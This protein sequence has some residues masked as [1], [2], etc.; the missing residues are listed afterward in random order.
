M[1]IRIDDQ[2]A[3]YRQIYRTLRAAILEGRLA[4]GRR[5]PSSRALARENRVS[6]NVVL[7][8]YDQLVAEGYAE[9]RVGS[10][11]YVAPT[12]P[13]ALLHVPASETHRGPGTWPTIR[14]SPHAKR[15]VEQAFA[16]A[17]RDDDATRPRFDFRYGL[18]VPDEASLEVWRRMMARHTQTPALNYANA[19]GHEPLREAIADYVGRSRGIVCRPDQVLVVNGS[20][21]ALDLSARVLL[22][23]GDRV[24]VEEP[25]YTGAREI[26]LAAGAT[27]V[28]VPVDEDGLDVAKAPPEAASARVAYVTPSHQFPT[29]AVMPLGH[30]LKL[31]EWA[32]QQDAVILEDDYDSEYRYEGRP[33]E[34]IQA[35]DPE[36]RTVYIGTFSKVLFPSLRLGFVILPRTL[37][38]PFAAAKWLCD[39]HT[40]TVLQ[41]ALA[42]LLAEGHFE[43]HL[44]R[45]RTRHAARRAALIEGL[46]AHAGDRVEV[47][48]TNAGIHLLVWLRGVRADSTE[49]VIR[50]A[51]ARDVG[52]YPIAPFYMSPPS[53]AGLLFGY[54]AMEADEIREGIR[55][56][57]EVLS[58][59][60]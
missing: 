53:R 48:G 58:A 20:Q 43:R 32:R 27:L 56:F 1:L 24:L 40:P 10:G 47:M 8:A 3:I 38:K 59:F 5:L 54:A 17:W 39:R 6:R 16:D 22:E 49:A 9:S 57:G 11:T 41:A 31:L 52:L 14:I 51:R 15:A 23:E 37:V 42:D 60:P 55:R 26:L 18:A 35:L 44:R 4:P 7:L 29:G 25:H 19:V 36:G 50:A 12:L 45:M 33:I 13:E 30:R 34:A 2:D 46:E 21:Q 28:P